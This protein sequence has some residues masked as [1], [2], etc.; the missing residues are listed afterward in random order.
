[1]ALRNQP[2]LPLY[3]KDFRSDDK[4][5]RCSAAS[6]GVYILLLCILHSEREYGKI[7]LRQKEHQ[8][9]SNIKN[10]AD[11]FVRMMPFDADEI[12]NA[13]TEL[14][15]FDVIQIDGDTL[16]QKRMV[17]DGNIS[18]IRASA[19]KKGSAITNSKSSFAA[20]K[21]S[22]K[23]PAKKQ[24]NTV[25]ANEYENA[26][27]CET[28]DGFTEAIKHFKEHRNKIKKPMTDHAVDL[29]RKKLEKLAPGDTDKQI[30]LIDYAIGKAWQDVYIPDEWKN[31]GST[32]PEQERRKFYYTDTDGKVKEGVR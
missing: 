28:N 12:E 4:L 22:S 13:L 27:E 18:E 29:F 10:F 21:P 11:V 31:Q 3:V 6:H 20:T 9:S 5:A 14:I 30:E 8:N 1:M 25:I 16:Y 19:G 7:L 15:D 2:Y 32:T 26:I 24:Q 17:R 23:R